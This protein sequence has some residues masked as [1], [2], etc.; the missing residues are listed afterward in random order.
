MT[1]HNYNI[2]NYRSD[3]LDE[4]VELWLIEGQDQTGHFISS[5]IIESQLIKPDF[6]AQETVLVAE[7]D[8]TIIGCLNITPEIAVKRA[9][10]NCIVH[11]NHR[12]QG[13]ATALINEA[14]KQITDMEA[15]VAATEVLEQN[16]A[17]KNLLTK[18]GFAAIRD[19]VQLQQALDTRTTEIA[20]TELNIG[21]L[22]AGEENIL[23]D[24][25]NHAFAEHWGFSPNT[26]GQITH[27]LNQSD[28]SLKHVI[29]AFDGDTPVG[30]CWTNTTPENNPATGKKHGRI[31]MLGVHSDYRG[32]GVGRTVLIAGMAFL[33]DR[34]IDIVEITADGEN[35]IAIGL[36]ESVG[37]EKR[38]LSQCYERSLG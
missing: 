14:T 8:G 7:K 18:L 19:F 37:F 11:P 23:T 34:D 35:K 20:N 36:Y 5:Q 32:K 16:I 4:C 2:R 27:W 24:L 30:Y 17:A 31:H 12:R 9:I 26:T 22:N 10:I 1:G 38:A 28:S 21:H 6:P 25:Q 15:T 29:M 3:D 33:H 13:V